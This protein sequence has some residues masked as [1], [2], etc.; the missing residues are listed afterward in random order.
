MRLYK[1][2][3]TAF[4]YLCYFYF[5]YYFYF[6]YI[7]LLVYI[8]FSLF[9]DELLHASR[10]ANQIMQLQNFIIKK[11]AIVL[12]LRVSM[13]TTLYQKCDVCV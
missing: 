7:P 5:V 9:S 4:L 6:M 8:K 2:T 3:H 11:K 13:A 12:F 1:Y 10:S